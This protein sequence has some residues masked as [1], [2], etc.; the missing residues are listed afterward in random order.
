MKTKKSKSVSGTALVA[1]LG[2]AVF[3]TSS[4]AYAQDVTFG[5]AQNITGDANLLSSGGPDPTAGIINVDAALFYGP[6]QS[7]D[8]VT[9]N[10]TSALGQFQSASS[11]SDGVFTLTVNTGSFET[12]PALPTAAMPGA[13]SAFNTVMTSGGVFAQ[14]GTGSATLSISSAALTL[15]ATYELQIFN[16]SA[17]EDIESTLFTSAN[18]VTLQDENVAANTAVN[19]VG[20]FATGTFT[21]T[22]ANELIQL[23]F[24]SGPFSPLLN[25]VNLVEVAPVPE[26]SSVA[27]M[28]GGMLVLFVG[29]RNRRQPAS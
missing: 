24:A 5:S 23:G 3:L 12:Y 7:V 28:L 14:H 26:P 16:R 8:G 27:S 20:Q 1:A 21:A 2:L 15:G 11:F 13:S 18:S 6:A 25:D 19:N 4:S 10:S 22:G 29:L 9:F 17:S